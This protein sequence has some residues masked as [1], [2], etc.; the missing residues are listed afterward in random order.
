MQDNKNKNTVSDIIKTNPQPTMKKISEGFDSEEELKTKTDIIKPIIGFYVLMILIS[1]FLIVG[2]LV[3]GISIA[4]MWVV[5]PLWIPIV[6]IVITFLIICFY[7]VIT[8]LIQF[9][10]EKREG[11]KN[12]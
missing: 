9:S 7:S 3:F 1:I 8:V 4:W 11:K 2:K 10:K 12:E 6:F 5:S